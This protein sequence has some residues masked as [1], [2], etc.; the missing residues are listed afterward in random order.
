[1]EPTR[2]RETF[3]QTM[4]EESL[5]WLYWRG[6]E[7]QLLYMS[8]SCA[9]ITGYTD[10]DFLADPDLLLR[11]IH[12]DDRPRLEP[13]LREDQDRD[14]EAHEFRI[15]RKD[16]A[17]RWISHTCHPVRGED[18]QLLGRRISNRDIT[19]NRE[20]EAA[21]E[22]VS[23]YNRT[24]L[25]ASLDPLVT[26]GAGGQ[27]ADVNFA[28]ELATGYN[29]DELVGTEFASYFAEP[30]LA[31]RAPATNGSSMKGR[32]ATIRS[33]CATATAR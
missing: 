2:T 7:G 18:G 32:C 10:R 13:H 25:E 14:A 23:A 8:P 30:G 6:P 33:A 15:T 24:L 19:A 5:D 31:W 1:M 29:R 17:I 21:L 3:F 16:G 28:T 4:V 26:I 22:T 9:R 20:A 12:P 27:I 11:I